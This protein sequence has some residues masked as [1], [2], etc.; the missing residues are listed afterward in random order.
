MCVGVYEPIIINAQKAA[1]KMSELVSHPNL[2]ATKS[3]HTYIRT[4]MRYLG[5]HPRTLTHSHTY[6]QCVCAYLFIAGQF[7]ALA[8]HE[9]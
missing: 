7:K 9:A 1:L 5:T 3:K 8:K 6:K 4:C 2:Y